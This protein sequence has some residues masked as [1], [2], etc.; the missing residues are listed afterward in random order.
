MEVI[1][2]KEIASIGIFCYGVC[3]LAFMLLVVEL[4]VGYIQS[5]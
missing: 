5:T 4:M 1:D 3:A 2:L